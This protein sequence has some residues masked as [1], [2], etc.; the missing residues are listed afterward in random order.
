MSQELKYHP[1]CLVGLYD[2]ERAPLKTLKEEHSDYSSPG[3]AMYPVAFSEVD[4]YRDKN[5][6]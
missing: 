6:Q 4:T 5:W 1:A 2:R 3:R